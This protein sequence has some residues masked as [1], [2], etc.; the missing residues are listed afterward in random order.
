MAK[1]INVTHFKTHT[2][3]NLSNKPDLLCK[4][5]TEDF[6]EHVEHRTHWY[7]HQSTRKG[8]QR[9]YIRRWD[10]T[11]KKNYHLHRMVLAVGD[12][13]A[14]NS[15]VDHKDNTDTLNN[16]RENLRVGDSKLNGSNR[17]AIEPRVPQHN[18]ACLYKVTDRGRT[19]YKAYRKKR[20]IASDNCIEQL[21]KKVDI[22]LEQLKQKG[23]I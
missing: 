5:D 23:E 21:K 10:N 12:Y 16:R 11:E 2:E 20:Y 3:F 9:Y 14:K 6:Y 1:V 4:I 8:L 22:K 15:I 19:R 7:I 18:G 17:A 13:C